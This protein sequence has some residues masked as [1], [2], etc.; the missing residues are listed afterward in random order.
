M[1]NIYKNGAEII[2]DV[3]N[4]KQFNCIPYRFYG[5]NRYLELFSDIVK[6]TDEWNYWKRL[7]IITY[8]KIILTDFSYEHA[9]KEKP[10]FLHELISNLEKIF[11]KG[12]ND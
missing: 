7:I 12:I 9:Q 2:N 5:H 1:N 10:E 4:Y 8:T 11:N 3:I 6:K